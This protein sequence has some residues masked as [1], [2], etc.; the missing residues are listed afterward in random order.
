MTKPNSYPTFGSDKLTTMLS[1]KE[2]MKTLSK[3]KRDEAWRLTGMINP[4]FNE[5][6]VLR[7]ADYGKDLQTKRGVAQRDIEQD[8]TVPDADI[9][10]RALASESIDDSVGIKEQLAKAQR[11]WTAIERAVEHL[12]RE[13]SQEKS[14]LAKEYCK[15]LKPKHDDLM[16]RLCKQ[17]LELHAAHNELYGLRRHLVD[18]EIGCVG[19]CLDLPSFLSAAN[20]KNSEMADWLRAVQSKGFVKELPLEFR[21]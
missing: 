2:K 3:Q 7:I 15:Q 10:K 16:A 17:M 8:Q 9:V 20:N 4:Q 21:L 1:D 5:A 14:I 11:E 19:I 12:D 6:T 13:I 18:S